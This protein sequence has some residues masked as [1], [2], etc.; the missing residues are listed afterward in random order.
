MFYTLFYESLFVRISIYLKDNKSL[1]RFAKWRILL[2]VNFSLRK[3][4]L[5]TPGYLFGGCTTKQEIK[6]EIIERMNKNP[7]A[8]NL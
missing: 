5:I 7:A 6:N 3:L 1:R 2:T 8:N 4:K